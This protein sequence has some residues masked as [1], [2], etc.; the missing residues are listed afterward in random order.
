MKGSLRWNKQGLTFFIRIQRLLQG[1]TQGVTLGQ[2]T[3]VHELENSEVLN[4]KDSRH[5]LDAM[6]E[7]YDSLTKNQT[8]N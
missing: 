4:P 5:W 3:K 2:E 1:E 7:E 8:C 6:K